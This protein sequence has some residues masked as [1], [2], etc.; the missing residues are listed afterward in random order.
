MRRNGSEGVSVSPWLLLL[1][2]PFAGIVILVVFLNRRG[3]RRDPMGGTS[4]NLWSTTGTQPR[5]HRDER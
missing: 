5:S 2:A 3:A 1:L 4:K